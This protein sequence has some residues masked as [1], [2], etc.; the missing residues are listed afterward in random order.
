MVCHSS[1][2]HSLSI[3][4]IDC[5]VCLV[6]V[7]LL[8]LCGVLGAAAVV[9]S[10]DPPQHEPEDESEWGDFEESAP[11]PAAAVAA[12]EN[13][14]SSLSPDGFAAPANSHADEP[15]NSDWG[16]FD[17]EMTT[18]VAD[19]DARDDESGASFQRDSASGNNV[20]RSENVAE[21]AVSSETP[22]V[23][24]LAISSSI[25]MEPAAEK[26]SVGLAPSC[27]DFRS[28]DT[29]AT[30]SPPAAVSATD[31][32][33]DSPPPANPQML[34]QEFLFN[35]FAKI[36]QKYAAPSAE[37]D[38]EHFRRVRDAVLP[39]PKWNAELLAKELERIRLRRR[40]RMPEGDHLGANA[41]A[42]RL[43]RI[44][45]KRAGILGK[46]SLS[47]MICRRVAARGGV[48]RR[49]TVAA[50][51]ALSSPPQAQPS[52]SGVVPPSSAVPESSAGTAAAP[53]ELLSS[54]LAADPVHTAVP[55][56]GSSV[57]IPTTA[58]A[59]I[60]AT[61][62]TTT[63][64]T[65]AVPLVPAVAFPAELQEFAATPLSPML[66]MPVIEHPKPLQSPALQDGAANASLQADATVPTGVVMHVARGSE[67]PLPHDGECIG[68]AAA[69][70]AIMSSDQAQAVAA[71]LRGLSPVP[72]TRLPPR[73]EQVVAKYLGPP[74]SCP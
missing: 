2:R 39:D 51:A 64:T 65:A 6:G 15:A 43:R 12:K 52:L 24:K 63:A 47:D 71:M 16:A 13:G 36:V 73:L 66:L 40:A 20:D 19:A 17:S 74:R 61:A 48:K 41:L 55:A 46:D 5:P 59:T 9:A 56:R 10:M 60:A 26:L 44:Q 21:N 53:G 7:T 42:S 14:A 25:E 3:C 70:D 29:A 72:L 31:S 4:L 34:L 28:N 38:S 33:A 8:P 30:E 54:F 18:P 27:S 45:E 11:G 68:L 67:Q 58:T 62:S 50:A 22:N 49:G 23:Q 57:G 37:A 69:Y 1:G 32:A 35:F